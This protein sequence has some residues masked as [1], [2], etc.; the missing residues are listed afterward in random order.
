MMFKEQ[1]KNGFM[2]QERYK[3]MDCRRPS[4]KIGKCL[5][6]AGFDAFLA[7]Y[8]YAY[9][10]LCQLYPHLS[11]R[12]A[13]YFKCRLV[14]Y[15]W[16]YLKMMIKLWQPLMPYVSALATAKCEISWIYT[17]IIRKQLLENN[18]WTLTLRQ[19]EA[20]DWKGKAFEEYRKMQK[21]LKRP[22]F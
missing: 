8:Q 9:E 5:P 10:S 7:K 13:L 15:A 4:G 12:K 16:Q 18:N 22:I 3:G 21:R 14:S 2:F 19:I 17:E 6:Q 11:N 1:N 20:I